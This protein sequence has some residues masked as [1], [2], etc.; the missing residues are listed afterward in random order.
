MNV[1]G[2]NWLL[3]IVSLVAVGLAVSAIRFAMPLIIKWLWMSKNSIPAKARSFVK[4]ADYKWYSW[5]YCFPLLHKAIQRSKDSAR[6]ET[7]DEIFAQVRMMLVDAEDQRY[8][9][10]VVVEDDV[11]REKIRKEIETVAIGRIEVLKDISSYLDSDSL[12]PE[13]WDNRHKNTTSPG[14]VTV[15]V[16][17]PIYWELYD[18]D[19]HTPK[20][21]IY[22]ER[23]E[24]KWG[25]KHRYYFRP[26]LERRDGTL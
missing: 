18:D 5:L 4:W 17:T 3:W 26:N 12:P 19:N 9:S 20:R 7:R 1:T 21:W 24:K 11:E 8:G 13:E 14:I 10:H 23:L 16:V 2:D 22:V 25:R 6:N 15:K